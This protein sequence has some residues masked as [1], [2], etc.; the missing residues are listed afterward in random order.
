[1][2]HTNQCEKGL[3]NRQKVL[4]AAHVDKSW[5]SA[6][7]FNMPMQKLVTEYCWGEIWGDATLPFKTRRLLNLDMLPAMSQPHNP[8]DTLKGAPTHGVTT[9]AFPAR[10]MPA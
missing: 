10:R 4:G 1:M 9:D 7:E 8:A 2:E 3:E 6:D 5:A